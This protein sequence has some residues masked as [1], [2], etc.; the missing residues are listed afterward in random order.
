MNIK[1]LEALAS[2]IEGLPHEPSLEKGHKGQFNMAWIVFDCGAPAC[3]ASH[4]QVLFSGD[5]RSRSIIAGLKFAQELLDLTETQRQQ[6][7]APTYRLTYNIE[8]D[9]I[10]PK[11]AAQAIRRLITGEEETWAGLKP[12]DTHDEG[13]PPN[14]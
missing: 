11:Q 14:A 7:L 13:S 5:I 3:L 2:Y 9:K 8:L 4:A 12:M 10:T 6:L 1:R